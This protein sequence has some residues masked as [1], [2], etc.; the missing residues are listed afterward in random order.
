MG[1]WATVRSGRSIRLTTKT[2]SFRSNRF[3][4]N[5]FSGRRLTASDA[6]AAGFRLISS[7]FPVSNRCLSGAPVLSHSR[8]APHL[9]CIARESVV[10]RFAAPHIRFAGPEG[11]QLRWCQA[12]KR[13]SSSLRFGHQEGLHPGQRLSRYRNVNPARF[14]A[15]VV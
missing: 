10:G 3:E 4:A 7:M 15:T 9:D 6:L 8:A 2:N 14:L 11:G 1:D 13:A 5:D 12:L